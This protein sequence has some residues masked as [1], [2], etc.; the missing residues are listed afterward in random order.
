MKLTDKELID[1]TIKFSNDDEKVRLATIMERALGAIWDNL[2]DCGMD[3]TYCTFRSEW[4]SE[5][6]VGQYIRHLRE[7]IDIRDD[8]L[9][10]LRKELEELKARTVADLIAELNQ[11]ITTEKYLAQQEREAKYAA[12]RERDAAKDKLTV[13]RAL[14]APYPS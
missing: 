10:D 5:M 9:H 4:G 13:W 3:G 11:Q 14:N 1:Y 2:V 8:E 7:E 6:H 12:E